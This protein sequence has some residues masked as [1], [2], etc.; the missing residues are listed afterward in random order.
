MLTH[1]ST[2]PAFILWQQHS[3]NRQSANRLRVYSA[4]RLSYQLS[5]LTLHTAAV[6]T[7]WPLL[8]SA[9]NG[10]AALQ[11]LQKHLQS[12]NAVRMPSSQTPAG[13]ELK[14]H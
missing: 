8:G 13:T 14:T 1:Y 6:C 3:F 7:A 4:D 12:N 10:Q 9:R 2:H 5:S 11:Q